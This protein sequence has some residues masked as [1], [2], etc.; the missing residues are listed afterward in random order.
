MKYYFLC[1]FSLIV[2]GIQAQSKQ[3]VDQQIDP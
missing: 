1:L 2:I 3:G